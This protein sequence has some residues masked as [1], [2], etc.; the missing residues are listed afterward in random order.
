[1]INH[2]LTHRPN[3]ERWAVLVN[4]YGLVGVD[5][6][7]LESGSGTRAPAGIDLREVAGGCICCS[8]GFMFE[9]SLRILLQRRPSRLLIEPTGLAALSGILDTLDRPG[10]KEG[11]DIRSVIC[12]LDPSRLSEDAM[13]GQVQDQIE[14]S[15]IILASRADLASKSQMEEF[16]IWAHSF[17][18]KKRFVGQVEQGRIPM[19]LLDLV[20]NRTSAVTRIGHPHETDHPPL[21]S[22][23]QNVAFEE[24][25]KM[26][27]VACDASQP[28]IGHFHESSLV[29]SAGFL[30]WE[31][32]VFD[33][34]QLSFWLNSLAQL[35]GTKRVKAAVRT[36]EGWLAYNLVDGL[37]E[38]RP[39]G[40]RRDSRLEAIF[41]GDQ[42]PQTTFLE[43]SLRKCLLSRPIHHQQHQLNETMP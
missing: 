18:P 34:K 30:C 35:P 26:S 37:M 10:I 40:H 9:V 29:S 14:A 1:M 15:D 3:N 6:A 25:A 43:E 7:L 31:E 28:I 4:E 16:S 42:I 21:E 2:L 8:A 41:E 23:K 12:L 22:Q 5:G 36:D 39:S 13:L 38:I 33:E 17:F 19:S 20:A 27:N 11:V 32:L 24:A